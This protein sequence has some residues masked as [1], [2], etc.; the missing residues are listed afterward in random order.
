MKIIDKTDEQIQYKDI[1]QGQLFKYFERVLIK[2]D[3]PAESVGKFKAVRIDTG[4]SYEFNETV[5]I[6]PVNATLTIE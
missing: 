1:E 2:T 3:I 4:E 5:L 6:R